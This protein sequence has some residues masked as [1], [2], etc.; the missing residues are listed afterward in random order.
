[1]KSFLK[2]VQRIEGDADCEHR[3]RCDPTPM[4]LRILAATALTSLF[5]AA[6]NAQIANGGFESG[7]SSWQITP[8]TRGDTWSSIVSFD[9]DGDGL[10]SSALQLQVGWKNSPT[11]LD[12]EGARLSQTLTLDTSGDFEFSMYAASYQP[13]LV[14]PSLQIQW[15]FDG[16]LHPGWFFDHQLLGSTE[17]THIHSI[18]EDVAA[19]T[20][21]LTIELIRPFL[22]IANSPYVYLDDISVTQIPEPMITVFLTAALS[23]GTVASIRKR[24]KVEH[25]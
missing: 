19:G 17:R 21:T 16:V 14:S 5:A 15:Y 23:L 11:E 4:N 18:M 12:Y 22:L 13:H 2:S 1:M 3:H 25:A 8:T 24:R 9:T 20:H 10:S 6:A 7:L